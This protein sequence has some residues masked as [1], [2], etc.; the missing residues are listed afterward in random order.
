ML[1]IKAAAEDDR[2][3]VSLIGFD[4]RGMDVINWHPEASALSSALSLCFVWCLIIDRYQ[5]STL[6]L[7]VVPRSKS[8]ALA[9]ILNGH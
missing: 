1:L 8:A 7:Y 6:C 5:K 3:F 4:C 9:L 2:K